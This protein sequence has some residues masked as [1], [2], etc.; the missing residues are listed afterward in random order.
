MLKMN[1]TC[2]VWGKGE[3]KNEFNIL[4]ISIF[5]NCFT[6]SGFQP[7]AESGMRILASKPAWVFKKLGNTSPLIWVISMKSW[8]G[9]YTFS[10]VKRME[11][12]NKLMVSTSQGSKQT[13]PSPDQ[14]LLLAS[15]FDIYINDHLFTRTTRIPLIGNILLVNN[16]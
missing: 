1:L 8:L 3:E 5:L 6:T 15:L 13:C 11:F 2:W 9:F 14:E 10:M 12:L 16:Y 7:V 4:S